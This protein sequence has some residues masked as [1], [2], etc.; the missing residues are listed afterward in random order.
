MFR[1]PA[2]SKKSG[3]KL[4][5]ELILGAGGTNDLGQR[6]WNPVHVSG[7]VMLEL[8]L[9]SLDMDWRHLELLV[10]HD[11][12][13]VDTNLAVDITF[14]AFLELVGHG[15]EAVLFELVE[16]DFARCSLFVRLIDAGDSRLRYLPGTGKLQL[17]GHLLNFDFHVLAI[18]VD[19]HL[20]LVV[21]HFPKY[22]LLP[23]VEL[24][25]FLAVLEWFKLQ[26]K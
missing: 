19:A 1:I 13:H 17:F 23:G 16:G 6:G 15:I 7:Q 2:C 14:L 10:Q 26:V 9:W 21:F 4:L 3:P 11:L 12:G 25:L 22:F 8:H 18:G 24:S 20:L 5:G